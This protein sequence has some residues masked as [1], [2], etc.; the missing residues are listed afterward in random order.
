MSGKVTANQIQIQE[1][2]EERLLVSKTSIIASI[3]SV[4]FLRIASRTS[5]V[6]LGFY[7]GS[8]FE[9]AA[10]VV[11]VIEAFYISELML[12]PVIGT[13]SDRHGRKPYMLY[14]PAV[15]ASAALVMAVASFL[16]PRPSTEVF[17]FELA[18][19]L[20]LIM[21]GRL[22][23]GA[24]TALNTPANL[25]YLT[26]ATMGSEKLRARVM[27]A[28]E[29]ATVGGLAL[30]IPF[31]GQVSRLLGTG[32]FF[33]VIALHALTFLTIFFFM[34]ES[35]THDEQSGAHGSLFENLGVIKEKRIFTFMPAWL[36]V[37]M[38]VGAWISLITIML[39]YPTPG[40]VNPF[41]TGSYPPESSEVVN[42]I[43]A[44]MS[45]F[46]Y[47]LAGQDADSRHP[48]QLLYGGFG[49]GEASLLVGVY[50]LFFLIGMS[51]WTVFLP[52]M[53]RT[54]VMLIG[55]VGLAIAIVSLS[56]INSAGEN[57][58]ALGDSG[59]SLIFLMLPLALLGI[60]VL[61]GFTPASLTHLG[62]ISETMPGK[63]G[64]VMGLYSVLLGIGQLVGTFIGGIFVDA[65]GFYGLML[66][67]VLLGLV[68]LW[69][70]LYM[71]SHG[72][73]LLGHGVSH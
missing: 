31:G 54:T 53:R 37:N 14:A 33:V 63:R 32:G 2:S 40:A 39:A 44:G 21:A 24:A 60:M 47:V 42:Y 52:K 66:F 67:S 6:V 59:K 35:L 61:S 49:Q 10:L 38:M 16:F 13:L 1:K 3:L 22:L 43:A 56:I 28:F 9:S 4:L 20:L 36:A 69:S 73:D 55:L 58:A 17:N 5:F 25:G 19:L 51:S 57:V 12:A 46:H 68:S 64:A 26:D 50:G 11:I 30:A 23:E 65:A 70:V 71:R 34:Q 62:A 15:G 7:L 48:N 41:N 27:T 18:A 72:H 45:D 8:N 29:V